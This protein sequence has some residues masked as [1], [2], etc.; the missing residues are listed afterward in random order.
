MKKLLFSICLG[1]TISVSAQPALTWVRPPFG[2]TKTYNMFSGS[3][4]E[5]TSG[6]NQ[7][8]DYSLIN[9]TALG[10]GEYTDPATLPSSAQS[11]FPT[12]TYVEV[13]KQPA[14]PF[15]T[16][17]I[18]DYYHDYPDS[19]VRMGQQHSGGASSSTWGDVQ[20]VWNI[21]FGSSA[22][23]R[24]QDAS[25]GQLVTGSYTYAGYGTLK[26]KLGTYNDVVMFSRNGAKTFFQTTPYF[27]M[28]M[29]VLYSA[30]TTIA[31]A[32]IYSYGTSNGVADFSS[33][34]NTSIYS[35]LNSN[36]VVINIAN[37][38]GNADVNVFDATGKSV[39]HNSIRF[40]NDSQSIKLNIVTQGIYLVEVKYNNTV[41]TSKVILAP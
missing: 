25:T 35:G 34:N 30:P 8:W 1:A 32:Y 37:F 19:L 38:S 9:P 10:W 4:T 24:Y 36:E 22:S 14:A 28:L 20:G 12:A 23:G 15:L 16:Q 13:W 5:P 7:V 33:Q 3:M 29:N 39:F 2:V 17:A 21:A 26:T 11:I 18:I 6:A 41:K 27:G 40:S 31:G